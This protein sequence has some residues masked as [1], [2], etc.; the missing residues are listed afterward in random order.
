[1]ESPYRA[2][3]V[4]FPR[5]RGAARFGSR[6][7][8][9][10]VVRMTPWIRLY[11]IVYIVDRQ[12]PCSL[13]RLY[14]VHYYRGYDCM[15]YSRNAIYGFEYIY[16]AYVGDSRPRSVAAH[17]DSYTLGLQPY[18]HPTLFCKSH[19]LQPLCCTDCNYRFLAPLFA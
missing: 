2:I 16:I 12:P 15:E 8:S 6:K 19:F 4:V 7:D 3:L 13:A 10:S 11:R 5:H 18:P 14:R 1:M 9:D 17:V